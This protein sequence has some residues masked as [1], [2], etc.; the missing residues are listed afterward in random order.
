M[1]ILVTGGA[2][3]I[4]S[5]I[6]DLLVNDGHDV[7]VVDN[8]SSGKKENVNLKAGF[9]LLD[10]QEHDK[11]NELFEK[12]KFD[13]VYHCAAQIDVRKSVAD[14]L[15]DAKTNILA[16]LN[17]LGLCVK[18]NVKHFIFSST[19]GAIYGDE[20]HIPSLEYYEANPVS[21]YGCAKLAIEK[22]LNFYNKVYG[23][24][25]SCLR[26]ANVYGPRQNSKGEAGVVA[27]FF[28]NMFNNKNPVIFGGIQTRDF[29]YVG[30]V[31]SANLLALKDKKSNTYN[32]GT[33]IETD[34]IHLFYKMNDLFGSKFEAGYKEKNKGEQLRSC[35]CYNKI[36]KNFGWEPE[37]KLNDGLEKS[38]FW[39]FNKL[40]KGL[41]S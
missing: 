24:K 35:L 37:I 14:P 29:V 33:G 1:K 26:Y 23:L 40:N 17:L 15:N 5:H 27:V 4:G 6:V 16:S 41:A 12:K 28:D 8:L 18:F 21:P 7:F 30:D 3:F 38:Y 34:I 39:F 10:L 11:I 9:F 13:V 31:A 19:G 20:A 2:G 22:Y 36:K 32:V 25:F